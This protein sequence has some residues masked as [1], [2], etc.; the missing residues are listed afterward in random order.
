MT[1]ND[2]ELERHLDETLESIREARSDAAT[3]RAAFDRVWA[4]VK[5]EAEATAD[6]A[7]EAEAQ[8]MADVPSIQGAHADA[9]RWLYQ[10]QHSETLS[11]GRALT[12]R[13]QVASKK[14]GGSNWVSQW[15]W[16]A[17][18]AA[19]VFVAL[20]GFSIDTP[21]FKVKTG[22]LITIDAL[23][24]E[25]F[26]KATD[27]SVRPVREGDQVQL[28]TNDVILTGKDG[29]MQF[30]IEDGSSVEIA[31]RTEVGL[32]TQRMRWQKKGDAVLGLDSGNM[33]V[34]ASDQGSGHLYVDTPDALIAVT[35]TV[36]AVNS[37]MK[38]SRVSVIEGEVE[39]DVESGGN[40]DTVLLPGQQATTTPALLPTAI[41]DEISWSAKLA[42]H[43]ALLSAVTEMGRDLDVVLAQNARYDTTLLDMT[44]STMQFYLAMPNLAREAGEAFDVVESHLAKSEELAAWW[45]E[46]VV[47]DGH[48]GE[49]V[50]AI[51]QLDAWGEQFGDEIVF[52]F[53]VDRVAGGDEPAFVALAHL[54]DAAGFPTFVNRF[55]D[56]LEPDQAADMREGLV[57]MSGTPTPFEAIPD[58]VAGDN[59]YLWVRGDTLI[60]A[61]SADAMRRMALEM[62]VPEEPTAFQQHI[63]ALYVD[64]VEWVVAVDFESMASDGDASNDPI[65]ELG[66]A[67]ARFLFG[68]LESRDDH[69]EGRI[70]LDFNQERR[71]I[72]GWLDE[73]APIG[74][75]DYISN[76]AI[77]AGGFVVQDPVVMFESVVDAL[78]GDAPDFDQTLADFEA[79]YDISL[80]DDLLAP[81][82]GEMAFAVE[83][84][85]VP[86]PNWKLVL[87]VYDPIGMQRAIEW[88]VD[89]ANLS[90]RDADALGGEEIAQIFTEDNGGNT[91]YRVE[92]P[93]TGLAVH[94]VYTDG[95]VVFG[96][97]RIQLDNALRT[98]DNGLSLSRSSKL[99]DLLPADRENNFSAVLYQ[100]LGSAIEKVAWMAQRFTGNSDFAQALGLN[101][102]SVT[103]AYGHPESLSF[104]YRREGGVFG[105]TI[106]S[107]FTLESLT[108]LD[109]L[110]KSGVDSFDSAGSEADQG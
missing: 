2:N 7:R 86:N 26:L 45:D 110:R 23:S 91:F 104:V 40:A 22:G 95:Y 51:E 99:L 108:D 33:I 76:E 35:G 54:T 87:Q 47:A 59:L 72:V 97:S 50:D 92:N 18:A 96:S 24:G 74:A 82:G 11:R 56:E 107:F 8:E 9:K 44:P 105:G 15:G 13:E 42:E 106:S 6:Q 14:S 102:P 5:S 66:L 80:R 36:F 31:P 100:D 93:Q 78:K 103:L 109:Q 79:E 101:G 89:Q 88:A 73:P 81:L 71:G 29:Q 20:I 46:H 84:P 53:G 38:G 62:A 68:E 98:R 57:M 17:A 43:L 19:V 3:E 27:G 41:A 70:T 30:T 58:D 34:E 60:A 85:V 90:T 37:G 69:T 12:Q 28:G 75:L 65:D 21:L 83:F 16:R 63:G 1:R 49:I 25:A 32:T 39:V 10:D 94:Y 64:G 77:M 52:S 67:D 61:A 55:I 4:R 48:E